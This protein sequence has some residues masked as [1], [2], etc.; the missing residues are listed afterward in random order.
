[1]DIMKRFIV[2]V[3]FLPAAFVTIY[4]WLPYT[5]LRTGGV[6]MDKDP[7]TKLIGWAK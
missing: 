3:G 5:Y 6:D 7:L 2:V 1:M 4:L